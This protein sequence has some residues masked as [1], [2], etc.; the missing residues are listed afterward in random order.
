[1]PRRLSSPAVAG[2]LRPG[3]IRDAG[4]VVC[5]GWGYDQR[6]GPP[7]PESLSLR[8]SD[9]V[10]WASWLFLEGSEPFADAAI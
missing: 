10:L 1:M 2:P 7:E 8:E 9:M 5:L 4:P 3:V 6:V